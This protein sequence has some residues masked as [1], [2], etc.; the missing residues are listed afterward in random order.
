MVTTEHGKELW[1]GPLRLVVDHFLS[2]ATARH[3]CVSKENVT[4]RRRRERIAADKLVVVPNGVPMPDLR[5]ALEVRAR[6]RRELGLEASQKIIGTV[7]RF[8]EAKGYE[9]MLATLELLRRGNPQLKWLAVGD[10]ELLP[11]MQALASERGM[12]ECVI[13]AGRRSDVTDLILAMDVWLMSSVR[14]GLPVALLEAMACGVPIVATKVGGIPDAVRDEQEAILVP[15]ADPD[16]L[17]R[18][19]RALLGDVE[20]ARRLGAAARARA[21]LCYSIESVARRIEE[22][23]RMELARLQEGDRCGD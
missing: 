22:I 12:S 21:E 5:H 18:A 11:H 16:A 13:W 9:H 23:Y 17:A 19:V 8:I 20:F 15:A 14:E 6:I 2:R 10:G 7:G 4:I 1:K 3:I